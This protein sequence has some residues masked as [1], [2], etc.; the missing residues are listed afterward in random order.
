MPDPI[1]ET[2]PYWSPDDLPGTTHSLQLAVDS[3]IAHGTHE[4][5]VL[6]DA[7]LHAIVSITHGYARALVLTL[8]ADPEH[9]ERN[10]FL[11]TANKFNAVAAVARNQITRL[12]EFALD[13]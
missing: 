8:N 4:A 5:H 11:T 13:S 6:A 10:Q 3:A 9:P 12:Q 2:L 1:P 7:Q